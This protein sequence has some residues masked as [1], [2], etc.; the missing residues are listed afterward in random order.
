MELFCGSNQRLKDA[1]Y[2]SKK[3]P[4]Q[5]FDKV[6]NAPLLLEFFFF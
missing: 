3:A 6:L 4:S 5:M 2:F 1:N